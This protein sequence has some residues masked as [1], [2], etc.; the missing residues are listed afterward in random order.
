MKYWLFAFFFTCI[1]NFGLHAQVQVHIPDTIQAYW[2]GGRLSYGHIVAT[3]ETLYSLCRKFNTGIDQIYE[4]NPSIEGAV[5]PVNQ[6]VFIP[7]PSLLTK[8]PPYGKA[9]PVF[10]SVLPGETLFRI[11]K[12]YMQVDVGL[13]QGLNQLDDFSLKTGQKL[14]LGWLPGEN[15]A[16]DAELLHGDPGMIYPSTEGKISAQV[17]D[18]TSTLY[19]STIGGDRLQTVTVP[20]TGTGSTAEPAAPVEHKRVAK[21]L[22]VKHTAGVAL[23]ISTNG[24]KKKYFALHNTAAVDSYIEINNPMFNKKVL[25]KVIGRIPD[26]IYPSDIDIIVSPSVAKDLRVLDKRFYV[27]MKYLH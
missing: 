14:L 13:I 7:L 11:A 23:Q 26:G 17:P 22:K 18:S 8:A 3:G 10:Y 4:Y 9:T 15:D 2:H 5:L 24:G 19:S 27:Q 21:P 12:I 25:A 16:S 6:K 20:A 1:S